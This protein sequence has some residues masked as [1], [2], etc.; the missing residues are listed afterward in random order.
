MRVYDPVVPA[1]AV[2]H[3]N[4]VFAASALEAAKGSD[5]LAIM[6][7]W[8]E[9]RNLACDA[10]AAAMRGRTIID[11]YRLLDAA[12]ARAAGLHLHRLGSS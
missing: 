4:A 2:Q 12:A 11:P 6:T 10:L 9:F 8:A 1:Q 3:G 5:V 7:P